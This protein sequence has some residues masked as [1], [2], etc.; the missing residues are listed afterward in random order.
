MLPP[1]EQKS[2]NN[3]LDKGKDGIRNVVKSLTDIDIELAK[4]TRIDD[5]KQVKLQIKQAEGGISAVN[6]SVKE[7][8]RAWFQKEFKAYLQELERETCRELT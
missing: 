2:F 7:S 3:E 8:M 6:S 1:E 5:E 4:A